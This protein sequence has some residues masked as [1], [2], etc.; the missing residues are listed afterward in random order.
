MLKVGILELKPGL[1]LILQMFISEG[2]RGISNVV[3][4]VHLVLF[5]SLIFTLKAWKFLDGL[6]MAYMPG[7]RETTFFLMVSTIL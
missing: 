1:A 2:D 5:G 3:K 4:R 7:L 6:T